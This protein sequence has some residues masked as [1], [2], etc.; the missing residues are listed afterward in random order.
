MVWQQYIGLRRPKEQPTFGTYLQEQNICMYRNR[1]PCNSFNMVIATRAWIAVWLYG[2]K[3]LIWLFDCGR[4]LLTKTTTTIS[5]NIVAMLQLT[6]SLRLQ[7]TSLISDIHIVVNWHLAKQG[8]R[9]PISL[10]TISRAQ[11]YSLFE[12]SVFLETDRWL[13]SCFRLDLGL[14]SG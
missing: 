3:Y 8:I 5:H 14:M 12:L 1:N 10:L 11:V 7:R 2:Y 4:V 6:P 9:W 13:S